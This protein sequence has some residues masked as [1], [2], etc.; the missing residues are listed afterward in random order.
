MGVWSACLHI[1]SFKEK[2]VGFV[3]N[4]IGE[5]WSILFSYVRYKSQV[6][7]SQP[8]Q[9]CIGNGMTLHQGCPNIWPLGHQQRVPL[10]LELSPLTW[11]LGSYA[12]MP[13]YNP[14]WVWCHLM[15]FLIPFQYTW[16]PIVSTSWFW[17]CPQS[18]Q[19]VILC[20]CSLLQIT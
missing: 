10:M 5:P 12:K 13:L 9:F 15:K 1:S 14:R 4:L 3:T 6:L 19:F 17:N 7:M 2:G 16:D 11:S 20:T 8:H 18:L